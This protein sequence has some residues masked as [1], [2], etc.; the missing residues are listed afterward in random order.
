MNKGCQWIAKKKK[1]SR[2][3]ERA[4]TYWW[5]WIAFIGLS[6]LS[7]VCAVTFL[8]APARWLLYRVSTCTWKS[9]LDYVS[10]SENRRFP[11]YTHRCFPL[12]GDWCLIAAADRL[13]LRRIHTMQQHQVSPFTHAFLM[14]QCL[15]YYL[16]LIW[17]PSTHRICDIG[18]RIVDYVRGYLVA[19]CAEIGG[20]GSALPF[21]TT[22]AVALLCRSVPHTQRSCSIFIVCIYIFMVTDQRLI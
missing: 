17:H 5:T 9:W 16:T 18:G 20:V 14:H 7:S 13:I 15:F 4:W 6:T 11:L 12:F 10:R 3:W 8:V 2:V 1:K 19:L 22:H 21:C